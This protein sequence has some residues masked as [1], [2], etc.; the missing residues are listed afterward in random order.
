MKMPSGASVLAAA[1]V[2]CACASTSLDT[3]WRDPT[4]T[5]RP[6]TKVLVVG[7]T[8]NAENRRIFED[9]VVRELKNRGV[10]AVASYTLIPQES[11]VKRAKVIEAVKVSNADAVLATRLV[12]VR[13]EVT[14]MPV[15]PSDVGAID[16]Y[17][18]YAPMAPQPTIQQDYRVATLETDF[19]DARTGKMVWWGRSQTFPT[20][21]VARVSRELGESVIG[22]LRSAKLL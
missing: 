6:F 13:T 4:Y 2:L 16:F 20:T 21:N 3:T 17:R 14:E 15:R 22:S 8:D 9:T 5:G 12:G 7:V 11:D 1:L 18:D 10:D 19:F